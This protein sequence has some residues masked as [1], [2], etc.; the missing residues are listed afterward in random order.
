MNKLQKVIYNMHKEDSAYRSKIDTKEAKKI[1][2][3]SVELSDEVK[4]FV[5]EKIKR[6]SS[7]G[8]DHYIFESNSKENGFNLDNW[9]RRKLMS[10]LRNK[11]YYASESKQYSSWI[12]IDWE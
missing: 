1:L 9:Q 8:C 3:Q 7:A 5:L 12:H 2:L 11:G 10:F 6:V 4:Q